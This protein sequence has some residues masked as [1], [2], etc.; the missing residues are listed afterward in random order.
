MRCEKLGNQYK[1]FFTLLGDIVIPNQVEE[2][3]QDPGWKAAMDEE[4]TALE[5]NNTWEITKLPKGKKAI[6]CR[7]VFTP[8]FHANR[9]LERLKARLI[10]KGYT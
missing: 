1:S 4:M 3:L 5:K 6:G 10:A 2:A 7:W 9:T 8:K